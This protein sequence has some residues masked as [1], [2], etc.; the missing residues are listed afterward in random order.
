MQPD[1][2]GFIGNCL[3]CVIHIEFRAHFN[4]SVCCLVITEVLTVV[5]VARYMRNRQLSDRLQSDQGFLDVLL[6]FPY[7]P[8]MLGTLLSRMGALSFLFFSQ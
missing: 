2:L 3:N 8:S 6:N 7:G 1:Y 5:F 4:C